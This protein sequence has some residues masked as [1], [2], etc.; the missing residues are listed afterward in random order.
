M[1]PAAAAEW[2]AI[3]A[4]TSRPRREGLLAKLGGA[5]VPVIVFA[6]LVASWIIVQLTGTLIESVGLP[7][8]SMPVALALLLVG[9]IVVV[10]ATAWV[11]RPRA[12][13]GG[14][15]ARGTSRSATPGVRWPGAV[16]PI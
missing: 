10:A 3:P 14:L 8:W 15:P 5:A 1:D 7:D 2:A 11:T 12:P 16:S 6:Y 9:L 13:A 4:D